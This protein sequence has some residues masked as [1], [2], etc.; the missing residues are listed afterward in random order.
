MDIANAFA[1]DNGFSVIAPIQQ[2]TCFQSLAEFT[3]T[4]S[5]TCPVIKYVAKAWRKLA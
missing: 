5:S 4:L 1:M 2:N 3:T